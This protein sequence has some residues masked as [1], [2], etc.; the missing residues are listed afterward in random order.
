MR[1]SAASSAAQILQL[2]AMVDGE[3]HQTRD[4]TPARRRPM[5]VVQRGVL[6]QRPFRAAVIEEMRQL[7]SRSDIPASRGA[8]TPRR[9]RRHWP[10]SREVARSSPLQPAA[11][12]TGH[13]GVA[14]SEHVE[15]FDR[16]ALADDAGFEVV[17][18]R[19]VID[20]A[21]HGAA[22]EHDGRRR[23]TARMAL[24]DGQHVVGA[25]RD[26]D[27]LFRAD[28]QVAVG[29]HRPEAL[30]HRLGLHVALESR[31]VA[32]EPPEVGPVVDVEHDLSAMLPG[33]RDRL[34]LRRGGGRFARNAFRS[35][36]RRGCGR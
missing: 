10:R 21:A 29:E 24:S 1:A 19:A 31:R 3:R 9:R 35:R 11:E 34:G 12:E 26:H 4:H 36:R 16:E 8:A 30:R 18:D 20:D 2:G 28:D 7:R 15:D 32:G 17:G 25:R 6:A 33:Q 14:G 5:D 13:E 27:L 22:L 23:E